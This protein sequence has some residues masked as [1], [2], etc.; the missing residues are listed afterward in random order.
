MKTFPGVKPTQFLTGLGLGEYKID[1][2]LERLFNNLISTAVSYISARVSR[3]IAWYLFNA[4]SFFSVRLSSYRKVDDFLR[5]IPLTK[6]LPARWTFLGTPLF[7][8]R[9]LSFVRRCRMDFN[10][11]TFFDNCEIWKNTKRGPV[12]FFF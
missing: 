2:D 5:F 1:N 6:S 4:R 12:F 10:R 3:K 9:V 11:N 8:A 7:L